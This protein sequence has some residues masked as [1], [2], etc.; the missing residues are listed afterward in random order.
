MSD[1]NDITA[2][3]FD[4]R[5]NGYRDF[6]CRL[7]PNVQRERVIGVRTPELRRL[8]RELYGSESAERLMQSLPHEYYEEDNLHAFLIERIRDF[9]KAAAALD[10]FLPY[11]NNWA[12]CD[13]MSPK[14]LMK[15]PDRL[16]EKI[17]Q[18]IASGETYAV[19][20]AIGR[21][22]NGFLG[23]RFEPWQ[24]MLVAQ[25]AA[26]VISEPTP[27]SDGYYIKM[28]AAWYFA[29]ALA[30]REDEILPYIKEGKLDEWT[31]GRAIQKAIESRRVSDEQKAL[32]R[33][34]R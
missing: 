28:M 22:M 16:C 31:R 21:L 2:L 7:M 15:H 18:W 8:A 4:M 29:T 34:L 5:D 3:L 27:A 11:V 1:T 14:A 24:P 30:F 17:K 20:F 33:G 23:D 32:L 10:A 6:Q 19:R 13:M 25:T 9:D 12:T 26:K